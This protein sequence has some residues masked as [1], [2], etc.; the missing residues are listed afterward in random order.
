MAVKAPAK[1][2]AR[3]ARRGTIQTRMFAL[4]ATFHVRRAK[5]RTSQTVKFARRTSRTKSPAQATV[6][7]AVR[8]VTIKL[9]PHSRVRLASRHVQ[10]AKGMPRAAP[11]AIQIACFQSYS[12]ATASRSARQATPL[13][14]ASA[15]SAHLRAPHA[16]APSTTASLATAQ[17]RDATFTRAS[18]TQ[19]VLRTRAHSRRTR[20]TSSVSAA[21][22]RRVSSAMPKTPTSANAARKACMF[23]TESALAAAPTAG[24]R[25][26]MALLASSSRSMTSVSYHSLS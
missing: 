6:L 19:N 11:C 17:T 5:T 25:M 9:R 7:K 21:R 24:G 4:I 14:P 18:A 23:P 2:A 15:K 20:T 13:S 16:M 1:P 12:R 8:E 26:K 3:T 10:T 22:T